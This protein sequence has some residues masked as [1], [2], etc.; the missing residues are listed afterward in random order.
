MTRDHDKIS[1]WALAGV[2]PRFALKP[3]A[4][5]FRLIVAGGVHGW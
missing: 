3:D 2:S 5:A 1:R 4:N